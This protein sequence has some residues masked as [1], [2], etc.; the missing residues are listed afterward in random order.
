MQVASKSL[1]ILSLH[2][3]SSESQPLFK[4][5]NKRLRFS[6]QNRAKSCLSSNLFLPSKAA[7]TILLWTAIINYTKV[8]A[9]TVISIATFEAPH[10]YKTSVA[11]KALVEYALVE[12]TIVTYPLWGF[13]ADFCCGRFKVVIT[14]MSVHSGCCFSLSHCTL[15]N[16]KRTWRLIQTQRF[17]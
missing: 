9:W 16:R 15:T 4:H 1:R 6:L 8:L 5:L 10:S 2:K 17:L 11:S 14:S 12:I 3:M 13:V 7:I